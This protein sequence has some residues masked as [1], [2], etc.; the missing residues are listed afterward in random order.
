MFIGWSIYN[1]IKIFRNP[2]KTYDT[3][4]IDDIIESFEQMDADEYENASPELK[5]IYI[6][7]GLEAR[8]QKRM[9]KFG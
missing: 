1:F 4:E 9:E 3:A 8:R 2:P 7:H 6:A 5:A